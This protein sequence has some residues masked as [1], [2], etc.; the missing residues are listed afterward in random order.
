M[1]RRPSSFLFPHSIDHYT[2]SDNTKDT[3]G[4]KVPTYIVSTIG[5]KAFVQPAGS[6]IVSEY[7]QINETVSHT[8]Y[9]Q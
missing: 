3:S 7:A 1:P 6:D 5:V 8:I 2:V 9:L 4:A